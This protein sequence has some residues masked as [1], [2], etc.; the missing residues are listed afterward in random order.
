MSILRKKRKKAALAALFRAN[1]AAG[2]MRKK[3][4]KRIKPPWLVP[5]CRGGAR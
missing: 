2:K 5:K 3:R 1:L 4:I